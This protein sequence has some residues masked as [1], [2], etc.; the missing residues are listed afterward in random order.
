M[1]STTQNRV[2]DVYFNLHKR[3]LSIR[4]V[5]T[6]RVIDHVDDVVLENVQ[7]RVSEQGRQRVLSQ[8]R[9][10]VHAFCRGN[11]ID[12]S[13]L[14]LNDIITYNPYMYKNFVR[15]QDSTPVFTS[16]QVHI[17]GRVINSHK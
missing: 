7:F 4:C 14:P 5:K 6:R 15:V 2:V 1:R 3:K 16:K 8:R 17:Q 12:K 11:I 13:T 9:K 10:N